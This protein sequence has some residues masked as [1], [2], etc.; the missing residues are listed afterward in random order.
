ML[1]PKQYLVDAV[2]LYCNDNYD[3]GGHWIIETHTQDDYLKLIGRCTTVEGAISKA[4]WFIKLKNE[5][6]LNC[7]FNGGLRY[8]IK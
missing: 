6:D 2:K 5:A 1:H 4:E 7:A 8:N 3:N